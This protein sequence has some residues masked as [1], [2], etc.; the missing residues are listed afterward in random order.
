MPSK[1][2]FTLFL[3]IMLLAGCSQ[4]TNEVIQVKDFPQEVPNI[5]DFKSVDAE[6]VLKDSKPI[7]YMMTPYDL[8]DSGLFIG[9]ENKKL[10][11]YDLESKKEEIIHTCTDNS[12]YSNIILLDSSDQYIVFKNTDVAMKIDSFCVYNIETKIIK[13]IRESKNLNTL[14][15]DQAI[16]YKDQIYLFLCDV[17]DNE[18][19]YTYNGYIYDLKKDK[20]TLFED[21]NTTGFGTIHNGKLYYLNIDNVALT[22]KLIEYDMESKEKVTIMEGNQKDGFF[23]DLKSDEERLYIFVTK[24]DDKSYCYRFD[25]ETKNV[26]P[27]FVSEYIDRV[28]E[29]KHYFVWTNYKNHPLDRMHTM[30]Y[31]LDIKKDILYQ[32]DGSVIVQSNNGLVWTKFN[33][34]EREIPKGEIYKKD[35]STFMYMKFS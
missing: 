10:I 19:G 35:N 32:Y 25:P 7:D 5:S 4:K 27:Y 1:R 30:Y 12:M 6:E 15:Y 21:Q 18:F 34:D 24:E 8:T 23:S 14:V 33:K 31:F 26:E 17:A 28:S 9:E 11:S 2:R 13:L 20:L 22:T 3:F 16:I 29:S